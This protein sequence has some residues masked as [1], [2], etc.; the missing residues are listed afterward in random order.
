MLC[1]EISKGKNDTV[2]FNGFLHGLNTTYEYL[3]L[4]TNLGDTVEPHNVYASTKFSNSKCFSVKLPAL[5]QLENLIIYTK[6]TISDKCNSMKYD[7]IDTSYFKGLE[8]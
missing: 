8:L 5:K 1:Y 3:W 2:I 7:F 4:E 6:G